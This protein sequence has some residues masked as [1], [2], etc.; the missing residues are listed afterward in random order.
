MFKFLNVY[1]LITNKNILS[2]LH[3]NIMKTKLKSKK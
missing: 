1:V 2:N 3:T